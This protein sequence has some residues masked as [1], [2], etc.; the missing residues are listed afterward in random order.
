VEIIAFTDVKHLINYIP[1]YD[2]KLFAIQTAKQII[3]K[4]DDD[5]PQANACGKGLL[6]ILKT[7]I[8]EREK[9]QEREQEAFKP[10]LK[11]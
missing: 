5:K 1:L 8:G 6:E 9:E 2:H 3:M 10:R 11:L 4:H 7:K